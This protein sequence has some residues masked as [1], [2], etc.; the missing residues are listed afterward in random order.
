MI[1]KHFIEGAKGIVQKSHAGATRA[2]RHS[3]FRAKSGGQ[4]GAHCVEPG[5]RIEQKSGFRF[6]LHVGGGGEFR[7]GAHATFRIHDLLT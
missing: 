2:K 1:C 4:T 3:P 6:Y 5:E 7:S